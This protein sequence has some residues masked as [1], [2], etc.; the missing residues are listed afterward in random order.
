M[1]AKRVADVEAARQALLERSR[2][3]GRRSCGRL[4]GA[5]LRDFSLQPAASLLRHLRQRLAEPGG[6]CCR[7]GSLD[8]RCLAEEHR[9]ALLWRQEVERG[10]GAQDGAAE[11]HE[12]EHA[13]AGVGPADRLHDANSVRAERPFLGQPTGKLELDVR[14]GHLGREL[15][16]ALR[17]CRAV[18]N[19]HDPD[20][21]YTVA[22][23]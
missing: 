12:H 6:N 20:H 14:S 23:P 9:L 1:Q 8:E 10:L 4:A 21:G 17:E 22:S 18:G 3:R 19:D 11:V 16:D 13:V 7:D 15:A 5:E 2:R